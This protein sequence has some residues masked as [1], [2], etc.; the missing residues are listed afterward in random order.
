MTIS[1]KIIKKVIL[2]KYNYIKEKIVMHNY[3]GFI[4]IPS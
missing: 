4:L 1:E 3:L 2:L